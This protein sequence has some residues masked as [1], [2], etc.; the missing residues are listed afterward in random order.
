MKGFYL[1]MWTKPQTIYF[2][3]G[4]LRYTQEA[5]A[6]NFTQGVGEALRQ[7]SSASTFLIKRVSHRYWE[8]NWDLLYPTMTTMLRNYGHLPLLG[9]RPLVALPET[10]QDYVTIKLDYLT[11]QETYNNSTIYHEVIT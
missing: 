6:I 2:L 4:E 7:F 1:G 11:V 9:K 3:L 8:L 5:S 10:T